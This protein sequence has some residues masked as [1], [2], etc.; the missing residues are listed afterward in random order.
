MSEEIIINNNNE[1]ISSDLRSTYEEYNLDENR[2]SEIHFI[3]NIVS[4]L[5]DELK[6]DKVINSSGFEIRSLQ[7]NYDTEI[8]C[9]ECEENSSNN[10]NII[11]IKPIIIDENIL[12]N[13]NL[14]FNDN[15]S[16]NEQLE[17]DN[18]SIN[19]DVWENSFV[20][21]NKFYINNK[22]ARIFPIIKN[23][24]NY[25]KLKIDDDSFSYIT[26][27]EIADMI[28]K[29]ISYHLLYFNLNPQKMTIIDYT[30]GVGGNVLS[31]SKYFNCVYGIEI[32]KL[33][34]SYL[35]NNINI[36]GFNNVK[37][38]N[39][40]SINFTCEEMIKINPNIIFMDPPWGG[41][42][43]K[44]SDTLLLKLGNKSIEELIKDIIIIFSKH[45]LNENN[46]NLPDY[47]SRERSRSPVNLNNK[48]IVLKLPKNY[49]VEYFYNYIKN[50]KVDNYLI[51]IYLYILN[52]MIIIICELNYKITPDL[53]IVEET[54]N[55]IIIQC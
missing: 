33:R 51:N 55:P 50:I 53:N 40:C 31:F 48:L 35:E 23:F 10:D 44:N 13:N 37:V 21:D 1:I 29:L 36:Y 15:L 46:S 4:E 20:D 25:S 52:K 38:I 11:I 27:R 45:Y 41:T 26:V 19:E 8:S 24:N 18:L 3:P 43:Y 16:V 34:A 47:S 54:N 32:D 7:T 6:L 42:D 22:I 14:L 28:T 30:A 5:I 2:N 17:Y 49:D 9:Q 39:D 12:I